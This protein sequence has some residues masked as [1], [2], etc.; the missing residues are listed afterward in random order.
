VLVS[1]LGNQSFNLFRHNEPMHHIA[2]ANLSTDA[3]LRGG[4]IVPLHIANGKAIS[5]AI[6]NMRVVC[7]GYLNG[8]TVPSR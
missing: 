4:E 8:L 5:S 6:A 2:G 7:D 3:L 1:G